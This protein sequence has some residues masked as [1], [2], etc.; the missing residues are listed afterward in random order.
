MSWRTLEQH[1]DYREVARVAIREAKNEPCTDCKNSFP[2]YVMDLDHRPG[3][4]K[5]AVVNKM[6]GRFGLSRILEEI[7]KCDPVCA[8]CHRIR[9]HNR[10]HAPVV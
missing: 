7:A 9:T 5:L 2:F 1:R 8:N 4:I 3:E 10:L 6:P